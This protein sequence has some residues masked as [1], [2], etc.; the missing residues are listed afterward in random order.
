[1]PPL[2]P[3]RRFWV[4]PQNPD[5]IGPIGWRGSGTLPVAGNPTAQ[6]S[7]T[8]VNGVA[9]TYMRSD[10]APRLANTAVTAGSYTNSNL[11][12]DPQGRITAASNGTGG[13]PG[14]VT[15]IAFNAP[16]T[17]GT[18][19]TSG[20]VGLGNVPVG[21]LNSGT[22][23]S[24]A[25]FWRGDGTW[26][27]PAGGGN[28]TT[29]TLTTNAL[30][31]GTGATAIGAL[32]SLGA[33]NTVLHGNAAGL[34]TFGAV[35]LTADVSGILGVA[36]G[37]TGQA[38]A[39]V[40]TF[41]TRSGAVTLSSGD[42]TGALGFTP[43]NV[44][45]PAGYQ[46][47]AQVTAALPVA[48]STPPLMN[49]AVAIGTGTTWAR[50]DHVHASD[51]SRLPLSGGTLT[52]NLTAPQ[53]FASPAAALSGSNDAVTITSPTGG[54]ARVRAI[55]TGGRT[56]TF[57]AMSTGEFNLADETAAAVRLQITATGLL[58]IEN[59]ASI[60]GSG[61]VVGSPASGNLGSG[62]LNVQ[63]NIQ[64]TGGL[65]QALGANAGLMFADR[66]TALQWQWFATGS[67][68]NLYNPTA[69]TV[70]QIS[71]AGA[72]SN[73]SGTWAAFSDRRLKE[74]IAPYLR[75][76]EEVLQLEPVTFR[77]NGK[78]GLPAD[79]T[80][81]YGLIADDVAEIM[82][83]LVGERAIEGEIFKTVDPGRAIYAMI[84]A[85]KELAAQN[86]A[87]EARIATLE[88]KA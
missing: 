48:S 34:P 50:A 13:A 2:A 22:G 30:T 9:A 64:T 77:Y 26:A 16:L 88:A 78:G 61:L 87:L 14:T 74:D 83:E 79:G 19:T 25:T 53:L 70:M 38:T 24:A 55:V 28:V 57:G 45:N 65:I 67:A 86:A 75:G 68:A 84:N 31:V 60:L 4:P 42:V 36:N 72:C 43:Y 51:T 29:G 32:G 6:V 81:H 56:W 47:A 3:P 80:T 52:G 17:G 12:I 44:T 66:A 27:A 37:G 21:N 41:N 73:L 82:P 59:G 8:A 71:V 62:T 58:N 1:M 18:I 15:S 39:P 11:T 49:G 46:T 85:V 69:G 63:G 76:I 33:V 5:P 10:A 35:S 40:L 7:G 23:A 20:T 54:P